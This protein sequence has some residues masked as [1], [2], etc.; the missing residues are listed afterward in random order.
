MKKIAF[1][2]A[3]NMGG[4]I[5]RA[6]CQAVEPENVTVYRPNRQAAQALAAETGCTLAETGA[7]AVQGA[8]YVLLCVKPQILPGVLEELLPALR[9]DCRPGAR[10]AIVSIAAGVTVQAISDILSAGGLELPVVRLMPNTPVAVGKGVVLMAPG[11]LADEDICR[12]LEALLAPCG[13]VERVTERELD[14][15]S[16]ISGCGPA[17]VYLFIEA[18][19][20]GGV[21]IG[22]PRAKAQRWAAQMVSGAAEM[23]LRSG[24]HPGALKDE[25]C[26]PGGTTIAGVAQLEKCAFRSAA[27]QAVTAAYRRNCELGKG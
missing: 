5:V 6:V 22:L 21:E 9:E 23:A 20:D 27:A 14:L 4:P 7:Q 19:A 18:L 25:V 13:L 17:F 1:I 2:G 16:A 24:R 15:G 12:D 8:E 3:G 26:S 10:P 11:L